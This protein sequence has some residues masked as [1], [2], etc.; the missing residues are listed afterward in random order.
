MKLEK[1]SRKESIELLKRICNNLLTEDADILANFLD[2]YPLALTQAAS[3]LKMNPSI[4]V[5]AYIRD[6]NSNSETILKKQSN[7]IITHPAF[8]NYQKDVLTSIN[9]NLAEIKK[10]SPESYELLA[11]C[12]FLSSKNIPK[13]LLKYYLVEL[14]INDNIKQEEIISKLIE[15]SQLNVFKTDRNYTSTHLSAE[16]ISG[17]QIN[18]TVHELTQKA[19]QKYLAQQEKST[20]LNRGIEAAAKFFPD[21]L[22]LFIPLVESNNDILSHLQTLNNNVSNIG[23]VSNSSIILTIRELEY[24]LS[25]KRDFSSSE[26]LFE[27]IEKNLQA[28]NANPITVVRYKIMK[29]LYYAWKFF[30]YKRALIQ[31]KEA[32]E[33]LNSINDKSYSE[34]RLMIYNGLIQFYGFRGDRKSAFKLAPI[35]ERLI[36][37]SLDFLGNQDV[38]YHSLAKIYMDDE[39]F[40][41]A[42]KYSNKAIEN[43]AKIK[44]PILVGDLPLHIL[45]L[46]ILI[47][48]GKNKEAFL[49]ADYINNNLKNRYKNVNNLYI[50]SF[51]NFYGYT[52][53][54]QHLHKGQHFSLAISEIVKAQSALQ[55]LLGQNYKKNRSY[56]LS[57]IFLGDIYQE[58][59]EYTRA[60]AEYNLAEEILNKFYGYG[61]LLSSDVSDLY[62]KLATLYVKLEDIN[63]A[64]KYLTQLQKDFGYQNPKTIKVTNYFLENKIPV[65]FN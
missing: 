64:Q 40:D 28:I 41:E 57:H 62:S 17:L 29:A 1:F 60:L 46:E 19:F 16:Y 4:D 13:T 11:F 32:L 55:M 33:M 31:G 21:K 48:S 42:L 14:G 12:S 65:G 2:D 7:Q 3:Y 30:D 36:K 45:A 25:G 52:L 8:D 51:T 58:S 35:G 47:R 5:Q 24:F 50:A 53:F 44:K 22:T 18:L 63:A 56:A 6:F 39:R 34:E 15:Y 20:I 27:K 38:F 49:K 23:F 37:D 9:L 26:L 43:I 10:L 54:L 61:N 59:K